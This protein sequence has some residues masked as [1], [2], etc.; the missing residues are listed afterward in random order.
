VALE[1]L[2]VAWSKERPG[3]QREVMRRVATGQTLSD[4][5][6]DRLVEVIVVAKELPAGDFGLEHL[7][8]TAAEDLPVC[9]AAIEKPEHVNALESKEPLTFESRGLTIV[10]GDNGSGK[11]GYAR[12]LKRIMR[13]RHSEDVLTDV[14]RDTSLA[15]PTAVLSI[16]IG[17]AQESLA[18]P[19][20]SRPELQRMLFYDAACGSAYIASE[21]DFPYRPSALF[22]MDGLIEACVAIRARLDTKLAENGASANSLP[23]VPDQLRQ[24]D[25][26]QFLSSLSARSSVE[27]LDGL[28][29]RFD[30]AKET[31]EELKNQEARLHS[32]DTTKARQQLTRQREKLV[33]LRNHIGTLNAAIGSVALTELKRHQAEVKTLEEAAA[34]LART[35]ESEPLPG[36]GS[37]PWKTMWEAA[38]RFSEEHA[39]PNQRFPFLG[40]ECRCVL[41]QQAMEQQSRDRFARFDE[42]IRNDAQVRLQSAKRAYEQKETALRELVVS[43]AVVANNLDDLEGATRDVVAEVRQLL[44]EYEAARESVSEALANSQAVPE[45]AIDDAHVFSRLTEAGEAAGTAAEALASPEGIQKQ[46]EAITA[47][48]AE[49]ELLAQLKTSRPAVAKEIVRLKERDALEAAK[50]AAATTGITKKILELSEESI[51]EVV[52]DT[53]TRETDRLRLERVTIA[54]TRADKGALLHQPKLVGAQQQVTV[55]RVLSEGERTALGL[56]AFFTEAHLDRSNSALILDDPVSSLDHI[57]RGLVATRLAALAETRQVVLFTHDVAFVADLKREAGA[58]G[59]SVAERSVMRS[60]ADERKPGACIS[61]HPWKAKDVPA[62]LDELRQ[63]LG[64]MRRE[65]S[66][67]G[68]KQF[69]DAVAVWAGNLSET[70][71]RIFSQEVVGPVLAEGGLE[72]RPKMVKVLARFSDQDHQEFD[73]SYGQVSQWAKRHDKSVAVNY[74]APDIDKLDEELRLVEGWFKRVKGYKA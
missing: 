41:C 61:T 35:F 50:T 72:V 11:S 62:R 23:T 44:S 66:T 58:R 48:R 39:Y 24:S 42:F 4:E 38:Q 73:G 32:A 29:E 56:A 30:T 59:V 3:W 68:D 34:L 33:A 53:F 60:R 26:G 2:I 63:E 15:Q 55:P 6:Y 31:I 18:W 37:S 16:R 54:R 28:I 69:E 64:R 14:F 9:L 71:E 47:R 20:S 10:Y 22:V 1:E 43:P 67:W 27:K 19:E 52:R 49:L 13:A 65:C 45:I 57:R 74:V 12:L 8:Q 7:P 21:S 25:A 46:L 70:W 36:V 40:N 17:D 51:T 5:E